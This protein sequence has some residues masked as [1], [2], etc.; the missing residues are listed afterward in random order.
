MTIYEAISVLFSLAALGVSF[1]TL[2]SQRAT[3]E[4]ARKQLEQLSAQE[5]ERQKAK[6]TLGLDKT[7]R[8]RW[9]F[10]LANVSQVAAHE[11]ELKIL[12]ISDNLN[13]II[14]AEYKAKFPIPKLSPGS[15]VTLNA[16]IMMQS[17]LAYKALLTWKNPDG[18]PANEEVFVSL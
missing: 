1:Y 16:A 6:L 7:G 10:V 12:E 2:Y 11:V 14:P 17:P 18:T 9:K 8:G 13:P 15:P 5:T 4:L 3:A